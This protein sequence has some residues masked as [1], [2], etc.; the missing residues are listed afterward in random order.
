LGTTVVF[1]GKKYNEINFTREENFEE[2]VKKNFKA[3]FGDKTI[4]VDLKTKTET[5]ELG[6]AIPDGILFD[7]SDKED[8]QFYLVEIE[9]AK[10]SFYNHIFP[11]I[12]KFFAFY[13]NPVG[14]NKLIEN[15]FNFMKNNSDIQSE[16]KSLSASNEIYK[17]LKDIIET[18]QNILIITDD[19]LPEIEEI[20]ATYAETWGRY[21]KT[22]ILKVFENEFKTIL[23]LTPEFEQLRFGVIEEAEPNQGSEVYNEAFHLE[24]VKPGVSAIYQK[25][26]EYMY[27][28]DKNIVFNPQHY[29]ISIRKNRNFA[30]IKPQTHKLKIVVALPIEDGKNLIKQHKIKELSEGVQ[31]FYN[32]PCFEV[33][34][35]KDT[36][37]EEIYS[38]LKRA[39]EK[40]ND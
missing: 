22:G 26:K 16:F 25:I 4:Y 17:K 13:K 9:L 30:Y 20:Q 18:S 12:T 31:N 28:L 23:A 27:N 14:R 40:Y 5:Q 29:Y 37:L 19:E 1:E 36:N 35:E 32:T 10:H 38:T 34:I 7:F 33:S 15:I 3:L 2:I 6:N 8:V 24:D 11:Q 21:V 39:Y